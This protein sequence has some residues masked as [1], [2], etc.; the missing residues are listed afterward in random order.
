MN[1]A[2]LGGRKCFCFDGHS[3]LCIHNNMYRYVCIQTIGIESKYLAGG[4]FVF[5]IGLRRFS[6]PMNSHFPSSLPMWRRHTH[7]HCCL[8]VHT[9]NSN[10]A[11]RG[12]PHHHTARSRSRSSRLIMIHPVALGSKRCSYLVITTDDS[13]Y[14]RSQTEG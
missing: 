3:I 7:G 14:D 5:F 1:S 2:L 4:E 9:E 6:P 11:M 10:T 12:R 8:S 13:L